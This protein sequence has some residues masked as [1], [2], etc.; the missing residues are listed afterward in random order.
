MSRTPTW[1]EVTLLPGLVDA[2]QHLVF[3]ASA[4]PVTSL[5]A[6]DE[7]ALLA[8]MQ[9]AALRAMAVGITTI[10]DLSDRGYLGVALRERFRRGDVVGPRIL[11]AGPPLTVTGDH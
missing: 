10:R 4:D 7:N 6:Q 3:D 11:A 9:D 2:H 8:E 5:Q 1:G